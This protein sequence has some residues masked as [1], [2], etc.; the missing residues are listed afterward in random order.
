M[1]PAELQTLKTEL[2]KPAY[3][4][5]GDVECARLLNANT[6]SVDDNEEKPL[7]QLLSLMDP[8]ELAAVEADAV[9][10]ERLRTLMS[11]PTLNPN[12]PRLRQQFA[13][14]FANGT[15]TWTRFTNWQKRS[16]SQAEALGL[17]RVTESDVADARRV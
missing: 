7:W 9:K 6:A 5:K 2:A 17:P 1:T 10:R 8:A 4:G 13:A 15:T 11:C 12:A 3:S 16:G 14:I